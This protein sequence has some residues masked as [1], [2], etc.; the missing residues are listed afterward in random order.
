MLERY[1]TG[2]KGG[3]CAVYVE[4]FDQLLKPL[5]EGF[6]RQRPSAS[7]FSSD[8]F[9]ALVPGRRAG[10]LRH[11]SGA[12]RPSEAEMDLDANM[13]R[14]ELRNSAN[15]TFSLLA[16]T[17]KIDSKFWSLEHFFAD[18]ILGC[19]GKR[20]GAGCYHASERNF[21]DCK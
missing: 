6:K 19:K 17:D 7:Y 16:V 5:L 8:E 15:P 21:S 18:I 14:A 4:V 20:V 11:I 12:S 2:R 10:Q 3:F 13:R 9:I 1:T